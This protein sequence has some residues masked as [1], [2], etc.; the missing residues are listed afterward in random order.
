MQKELMNTM[1]EV[2]NLRLDNN[3]VYFSYKSDLD[4]Y[5]KDLT[6]NIKTDE[7]VESEEEI[8]NSKLSCIY[9]AIKEIKEQIKN[10]NLQK[11]FKKIWY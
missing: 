1:I 11:E 7:I 9:H 3:L 2:K 8:S 6:Y 4:D 5:F 10:N